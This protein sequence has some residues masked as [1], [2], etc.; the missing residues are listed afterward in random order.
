ME[1]NDYDSDCF[2]TRCSAWFYKLLNNFYTDPCRK[3]NLSRSLTR[4][5]CC[6]DAGCTCHQRARRHLAQKKKTKCPFASQAARCNRRTICNDVTRGAHAGAQQDVQSPLPF[7]PTCAGS[8]RGVQDGPV[9]AARAR[10]REGKEAE[11]LLP[12]AAASAGVDDDAESLR[13]E[14]GCTGLGTESMPARPRQ[15]SAVPSY[16]IQGSS[17]C[18]DSCHLSARLFHY[19]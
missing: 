3:A 8:A 16:C 15:L 9:R 6:T 5:Y 12:R 10:D 13:V 4:G 11:S 2:G 14:T 19:N 7:T 17:R 18:I 1:G